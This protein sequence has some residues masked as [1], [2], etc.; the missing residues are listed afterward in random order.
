MQNLGSNKNSIQD[1]ILG[2]E[3]PTLEKRQTYRNLIR[4]TYGVKKTVP[5]SDRLVVPPHSTEFLFSAKIRERFE[6]IKFSVFFPQGVQQLLKVYIF[7]SDN[8]N[9]DDQGWN[10]LA[11]YS[12]TPFFIGD[13][14]EVS[15]SIEG[16]EF[17]SN[18]KYIK[19]MAVNESD[20]TY[21]IN[22][23]IKIKTFPPMN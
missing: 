19:I 20:H 18:E 1:T 2:F 11:E 21:S 16:R 9:R 22:T 14:K 4:S 8:T 15:E 17:P 13:N 10:P 7:V 3:I 5:L 23:R 6:L 12:S